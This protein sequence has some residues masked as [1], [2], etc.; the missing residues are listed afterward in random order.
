MKDSTYYPQDSLAI[1]REQC[2]KKRCAA[3]FENNGCFYEQY[4]FLVMQNLDQ[5]PQERHI[6]TPSSPIMK[7]A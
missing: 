1:K 3:C 5:L 4:F 7:R 2:D 6:N